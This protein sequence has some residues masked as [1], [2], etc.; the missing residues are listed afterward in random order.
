MELS[1]NEKRYKDILTA[2][3]KRRAALDARLAGLRIKEA[4]LNKS[5]SSTT[6]EQLI[7]LDVGGAEYHTTATTLRQHPGSRL[8]ARSETDS[9]SQSFSYIFL[10]PLPR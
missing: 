1:N 3:E 2:L 9:C 5:S 4:E 7:Y 10:T 8:E 6:P